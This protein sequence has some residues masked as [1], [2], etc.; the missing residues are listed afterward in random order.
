MDTAVIP[1]I[2]LP[3][4]SLVTASAHCVSEQGQD[5]IRYDRESLTWTHK[6][7]I[8]LYLAHVARKKETRKQT[9]PVPLNTVQVKIHEGSPEGIRVTMDK[10]ICESDEF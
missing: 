2:L 1:P 4:H 8:Q 7:S 9:T 6:L 10:R 3:C 5:T